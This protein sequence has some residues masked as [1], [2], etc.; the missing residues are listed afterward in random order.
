MPWSTV[1]LARMNEALGH[2]SDLLHGVFCDTTGT[3]IEHQAVLNN[4]RDGLPGKL[5]G[6]IGCTS[7]AL[8]IDPF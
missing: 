5:P 2:L 8:A 7:L 3:A 1:F 4:P 6:C